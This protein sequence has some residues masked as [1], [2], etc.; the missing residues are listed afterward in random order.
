MGSGV[1]LQ[2]LVARRFDTYPM[3]AEAGQLDGTLAHALERYIGC[4]A[5]DE[6]GECLA[7]ES[8]LNEKG[9]S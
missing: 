7:I 3:E 2:R 1:L 8:F 5:M 6:G 4:F 9:F